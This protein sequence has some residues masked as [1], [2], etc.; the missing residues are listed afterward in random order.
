MV[1]HDFF[2]VSLSLSSK[3]DWVWI[4]DVLVD[5]SG[6]IGWDQ[7]WNQCDVSSILYAVS[8]DKK[9]ALSLDFPGGCFSP[10]NKCRNVD[11][12]IFWTLIW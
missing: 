11:T 4:G 3:A 10:I 5:G 9:I 1:D 7:K 2:R 6:N 12:G 8:R